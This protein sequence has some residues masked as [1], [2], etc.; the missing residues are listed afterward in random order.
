MRTYGN[1]YFTVYVLENGEVQIQDENNL[2]SFDKSDLF[3]PA[4]KLTTM[5]LKT[6]TMDNGCSVYDHIMQTEVQNDIGQHETRVVPPINLNKIE[7]QFNAF[8]EYPNLLPLLPF[9]QPTQVEQYDLFSFQTWKRQQDLTQISGS[10]MP[11]TFVQKAHFNVFKQLPS[12]L[13]SF[14]LKNQHIIRFKE[15][16]F[17]IA[18]IP[19]LCEIIVYLKQK[20]PE[21][22]QLA[23][24]AVNHKQIVACQA[25]YSILGDL[26]DKMAVR[27]LNK[28]Q[29]DFFFAQSRFLNL[30]VLFYQHIKTQNEEQ[31]LQGMDLYFAINHTLMQ[32]YDEI[33]WEQWLNTSND[34]EDI[35][36]MPFLFIN[37]PLLLNLSNIKTFHSLLEKHM[38]C[39]KLY[40]LWN[41]N[42]INNHIV[43]GNRGSCHPDMF[44]LH[45]EAQNTGNQ[46][47]FLINDLLFYPLKGDMDYLIEGDFMGNCIGKREKCHDLTDLIQFDTSDCVYHTKLYFHVVR[48][49]DEEKADWMNN[50][51][52][53]YNI[54]HIHGM[55]HSGFSIRVK[56]HIS[57]ALA[58]SMSTQQLIDVICSPLFE[59]LIPIHCDF[60]L[61]HAESHHSLHK[62][63]SETDDNQLHQIVETIMPQMEWAFTRIVKS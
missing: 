17:E 32:I 43:N 61:E 62:K 11:F 36:N 47:A 37:Q 52:K 60:K 35:T 15:N 42:L 13:V 45:I 51:N 1:E 19:L 26:L 23:H 12:E 28:Q 25:L 58:Q 41:H 22:S 21:F 8:D 55:Q 31:L 14:C 34:L 20:Y 56:T 7:K 2:R 63:I 59:K 27:K 5:I 44:T 10:K 6:I 30:F 33:F 40:Q 49:S 57:F 16:H 29:F 54:K 24:G 3:N 4:N 9:V 50:Q 46:S 48:L 38:K 18:Q 53:N 39:K